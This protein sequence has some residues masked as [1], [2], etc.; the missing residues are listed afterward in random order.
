MKRFVAWSVAGLGVCLGWGGHEAMAA[1]GGFGGQ[2]VIS[3]AGVA[4]CCVF[5]TDLDGDGDVDVMSASYYDDE[6]MWYENAG[7]AGGFGPQHMISGLAGGAWHVSAADVDGDG[8]PDALSASLL[9]DTVAWYENLM[10]VAQ[11]YMGYGGP[12]EVEIPVWG[13]ALSSG[14][15]ATFTLG[16]ALPHALTFFLVSPSFTP[17]YVWEVGGT[18][19]PILPPLALLVAA[20][21]G[22]GAI[23]L[24]GAVPGGSGPASIYVQAVCQDAGQ[25][26]GFAVSNCVRIDLLR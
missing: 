22:K 7:S 19:C 3:T 4:P 13:Q 24:P 21:D 5:A 25:P 6:V 15:A 9:D 11:A 10:G 23:D 1:A 14:H 20:A 8:D 18:L 12:G 26:M 17:T 16:G 2:N